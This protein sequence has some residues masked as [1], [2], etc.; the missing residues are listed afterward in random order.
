MKVL[1]DTSVLVTAVVSHLPHHAAA[2][3]CYRRHRRVGRTR[4]GVCTTHALA[5]CYA[6]LTALPLAPRIAPADAVRLVIGNFVEHLQVVD[7][8]AGDYTAAL[9]RVA[10]LSLASGVVYDALHLVCAERVGCEH[11]Y[12]Y[13]IRD[14]TRLASKSTKVLQPGS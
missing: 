6:T 14:F 9:D 13:N 4:T 1:F 11:L 10:G 3:A 8:A 2:L 5:E 12:T 7:L